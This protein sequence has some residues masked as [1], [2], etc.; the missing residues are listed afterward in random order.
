MPNADSIWPGIVT[1]SGLL[2]FLWVSIVIA[3]LHEYNSTDIGAEQSSSNLARAFEESTRRTISQIDQILLS[4]RAFY[5]AK[6]DQFD[7]DAWARTQT[8]PDKMTAAI[9]MADKTGLIFAD[10]VRIPPGV[11]IADRPH[12]LIQKNPDYDELYISR[13]VRGRVSGK[14]SIQ[15][16][17]KLLSPDKEFAGVTTFSLSCDELSRFYESLELGRGFVALL[18]ADGTV[19][20]RGPLVSGIIGGSIADKS[21]LAGMLTERSGTVRFRSLAT[22]TAQIASFRHLQDYPVIVVVGFDTHTV[23]QQFNS[24]R[25]RTLV[26][27]VVITF[28]ICLIGGGWLHQK[29]RSIAS[30]RA[31]AITLETISQGI[32]MVDA[33]GQVPV[34]NPRALHLLG[35]ANNSTEAARHAAALRAVRL[36]E[37]E[38]SQPVRPGGHAQVERIVEDVRSE[39]VRE[40]GTI[41]EVRN[42]RLPDGG[43]VQTYTD[44]TEQRHADARVRYLALHDTLTGLPNR[45][46]LRQRILDFIEDQSNADQLTSIMMIDLDGFK[47][48]NDTL[49]HDVGDE[50]LVEVASRLQGLAREGD[51]VARL[52]GDEFIILQPGLTR[53]EDAGPLA[54][55]LLQRLA[56][57]VQVGSHQVRIGAS[58]GISFFPTDA[59]NGETLL[60]Y[61]DIA[62]YCAKADGRGTYRYF[63]V[64]MTYA[65]NEHRLLESGLRRALDNEEFE[66]H[67]QPM[68]NC[69]TLQITGFEALARWRHPTRGYVSPETFI[70]VIEECGLV[71]RFGLW[72]IE[73]ACRTAAAWQPPCR[74]AVNVSSLQLRDGGLQDDVA[75]IL[76]RTGL[77]ASLLEIEVTESVMA[78]D[79][80][81]VVET[82]H[83]LKMMGVRIALDDFG[84]GYSS[85]SYLRRFSFDKIKIDKSFVQGQANDHGVRVILEAILGMCRNLG[86]AVVGEGVETRQQLAMLRTGG[87]TEVQGHLLS[88]SMPSGVVEEFLRNNARRLGGEIEAPQP[89]VPETFEL[90]R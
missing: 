10:T 77:P 14:D 1:I 44:V 36:A 19:L 26:G 2:V 4:A 37:A 75:A 69:A 51:F 28:A 79:S 82:L 34:I 30:N 89:Q 74:I 71:N 72:V 21:E 43:F 86:L 16:T 27:G 39:T 31:L 25:N 88:R 52:G 50:L 13:P 33:K 47:G 73:K 60:K 24:L 12:F 90:V 48:V 5:H 70:P 23:F 78:E 7:F 59:Q 64:Q 87:C 18:L 17:R 80:Q 56:E 46:Q 20:A 81:P 49:G 3:M 22:N 15:F 63:D 42:H 32:L 66:L 55:R 29:R 11:T 38:D 54:R 61:A 6:G 8:L 57:P 9:G 40:D 41:I 85:L 58:I 76:I 35:V 83:A 53:R 65:V 68:F 67:F 84:T 45:V 62:L